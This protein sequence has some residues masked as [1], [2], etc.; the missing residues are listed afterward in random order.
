MLLLVAG[1]D[2]AIS[3]GGELDRESDLLQ[4]RSTDLV[5]VEVVDVVL[6]LLVPPPNLTVVA[7]AAAG[8]GPSRAVCITGR[9][10]AA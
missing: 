4:P 1:E 3:R 5:A 9:A 8:E 2:V 6:L 10:T 7:A